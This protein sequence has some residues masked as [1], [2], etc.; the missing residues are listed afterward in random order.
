MRR[1]PC[2]PCRGACGAPRCREIGV[3][4]LGDAEEVGERDW[5]VRRESFDRV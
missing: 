5:A 3:V 4:G 1:L 2:V